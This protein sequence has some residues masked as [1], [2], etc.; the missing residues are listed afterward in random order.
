MERR[1]M[2]PDSLDNI[3]KWDPEMAEYFDRIRQ[4][5]DAIPKHY[6]M[7]IL[8][9]AEGYIDR[10]LAAENARKLGDAVEK[11]FGCGRYSRYK[12]PGK[13]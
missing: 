7:A 9:L 13:K 12:P 2:D 1:K 4:V 6:W 5:L 3:A 10:H 8:E 11:F